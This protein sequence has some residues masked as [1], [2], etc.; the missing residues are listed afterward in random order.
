MRRWV[1]C[2]AWS[3]PA[4]IAASP[5]A[6][7]LADDEEPAQPRAGEREPPRTTAYRSARY[8]YTVRIPGGW[9]RARVTLT[10][11]L[12]DPREILTVATFP[13]KRVVDRPCSQLPSAMHAMRPTDV[14]VTVQERAGRPTAE[15]RPRPRRFGPSMGS[16]SVARDC[17]EPPVPFVDRM[18][19]FRDGRR[20]FH[21]FVL[22][23][24]KA[25]ARARGAAY[26]VLDSLELDPRVRPD[27]EPAG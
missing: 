10:P 18:I 15:F 27:W 26:A 5:T 1:R 3:L 7:D 25:P 6:C 4:L 2:L 11:D 20:A 9:H 14:V 21:V 23:G 13:P 17:V 19:N 12:L 24:K 22:V 8:G 16:Q